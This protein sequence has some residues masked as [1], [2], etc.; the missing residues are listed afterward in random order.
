[1]AFERQEVAAAFERFVAV[2]DSGDWNA[3]ADLHSEDCIWLEHHL[4]THRGR[5]A[6]RRGILEVMKPVPMMFFPVDW[7]MIEGNRV[8]AYIWQQL[9]DPQAGDAVYRFGNVTILEYA[10]DGEWSFQ[11]DLYNPREANEVIG[12]WLA[13]GGKLAAPM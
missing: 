10:G 2:G 9:P 3:W 11:E 12:R 1:M 7:Y 4:G 6:I 8:V 5:E 13:A